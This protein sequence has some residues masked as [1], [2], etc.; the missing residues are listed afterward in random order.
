MLWRFFI[1]YTAF[2]VLSH[3]HLRFRFI[4]IFMFA[5]LFH[6][7]LKC[8]S[9]LKIDAVTIHI[10]NRSSIFLFYF[11]LSEPVTDAA[12]AICIYIFLMAVFTQ[13]ELYFLCLWK[14]S[15]NGYCCIVTFDSF[16]YNIMQ[17]SDCT[18]CERWFCENTKQKLRRLFEW[19][20][21]VWEKLVWCNAIESVK[22]RS[23]FSK[24][25]TK[26]VELMF[27]YATTKNY[28]FTLQCIALT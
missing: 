18:E 27:S 14:T 15:C 12:Y 17:G 9:Q 19:C 20:V 25:W 24:S 22:F 11:I 26:A 7:D 16:E 23:F 21:W 5:W 6:V 8:L 1:H 3:T 4:F 28:P 10:M 13:T 2:L